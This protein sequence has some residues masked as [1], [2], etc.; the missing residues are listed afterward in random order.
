MLGRKSARK[1][2]RRDESKHYLDVAVPLL[3]FLLE[4]VCCETQ[5]CYNERNRN[6]R[7]FK[8]NGA[9]RPV[10]QDIYKLYDPV[11]AVDIFSRQLENPKKDQRRTEY[12]PEEK[13][14][15]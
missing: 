11:G 1:K 5:G 10:E 9:Y 4:S 15:R 12:R 13:I 6:L 14:P 3:I 2:Q 8:P 7:E